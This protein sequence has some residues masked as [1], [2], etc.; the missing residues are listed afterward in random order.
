MPVY[1]EEVATGGGRIARHPSPTYAGVVY[2][3]VIGSNE[4]A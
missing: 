3:M 2:V 4:V 1:D